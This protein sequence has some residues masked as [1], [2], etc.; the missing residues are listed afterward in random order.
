MLH[1]L[2]RALAGVGFYV[3]VIDTLAMARARLSQQ[4]R[5]P[6]DGALRLDTLRNEF[7]LPRYASHH[8][9]TDAI[10]TAELFCA[11]VQ[12]RFGARATFGDV[13]P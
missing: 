4:D 12:H 6:A 5:L 11:L 2:S 1:R 9:L 8:G 3:P 10:A 7:G 13:W